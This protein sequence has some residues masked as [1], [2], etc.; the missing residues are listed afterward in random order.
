M[1][2]LYYITMFVLFLLAGA[3]AI[4]GFIPD[5]AL[6][7]INGKGIIPIVGLF[8][9]WFL[10]LWI[11]KKAGVPEDSK[12]KEWIFSYVV[13][14][15]GT[16]VGIVFLCI[17]FEFFTVI[18]LTAFSMLLLLNLCGRLLLSK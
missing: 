10:T 12:S 2:N 13:S 4:L 15:I 5:G 3:A 6:W 7:L 18:S 16:A 11:M 14:S 1:K 9:N 17:S 8:A